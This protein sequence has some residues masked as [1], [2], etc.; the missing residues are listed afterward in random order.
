[1]PNVRNGLV[2]DMSYLSSYIPEAKNISRSAKTSWSG[3]NRR[4]TQDSGEISDA[5]NISLRDFPFIRSEKGSKSVWTPPD[6]HTVVSVHSTGDESYAVITRKEG[7][8]YFHYVSEDKRVS[9]ADGFPDEGGVPSIA[10]FNVYEDADKNIVTATFRRMILIYPYCLSFDPDGEG[11]LET[12]NISDNAVP[13]LKNVAVMNGRVFGVLD[14]KFYASEWNS[15]A[16]WNPQA[17]DTTSDEI[18]SLA[19]VSTSQSDIDASGEFTGIAVYDGHV[20]GFKRNFMHMLYNNKNPFRIVDVAKVGALSQEAICECGQILFFA[21]DDGVYAF[22]GGYPKRISDNLDI[23]DYGGAVLGGDDRTLYCFIPSENKIFSYDTV[24]GMWGCLEGDRATTCIQVGNECFYSTSEGVYKLCG[25]EH[26]G[27]FIETDASFG[28]SLVEKKI[29]RLRLQLCHPTHKEGDYV[30]VEVI[31]SNG[32]A[33]AKTLNPLKEGN[34][35]ISMITR[36]TCDFGQK[37][38]ISG[39]GEWEV[40]YLQL[41]YESGGEKYV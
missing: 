4:Q 11:V 41:D 15:Y 2:N 25:G 18:A 40:R 36:M 1:M 26:G 5:I 17:A 27:F 16:G 34:S 33:A 7:E 30:R 37:I 19:W 20:I 28:G 8:L 35:I 13:K 24:N 14:G 29:K 3:L 23:D 9:V 6:G 31:K 22:T 10:V 38:R 21:S 39:K 32:V 12:L